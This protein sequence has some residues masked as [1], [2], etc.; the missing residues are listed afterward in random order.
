M[1][2]IPLPDPQLADDRVR[3]RPWRYADAEELVAGWAD[4]DVAR[5]N[6]VP[7]DTSVEAARRWIGGWSERVK[8]GIS[9]DLVVVEADSADLLGEVGVSKFDAQH[10]SA[11]MGFWLRPE[12]RGKGYASAAVGL[13]AEWTVSAIG[14]RL[15]F[16]RTDPGNTDSAGVLLR[17]GFERRGTSAGGHDIWKFIGATS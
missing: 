3:L 10:G 11:E 2:K 15:L 14:V 12:A 4:P 1:I 16:T 5:W 6:A 9:L 17:A 7:T 8:T 13:L